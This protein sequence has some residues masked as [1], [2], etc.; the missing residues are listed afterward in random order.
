MN[1]LRL[2]FLPLAALAL[3]SPPLSAQAPRILVGPNVLVSHDEGVAHAELHVAAH[4][5]DAQRLIGMATTVRDAASK[6]TLELY[7][8][9]DGGF[10]WKGS[11]P[12]HLLDKGASDPIVGY[13]LHGTPLGVALGDHGMWVYRSDD[14]GFTWDNGVRAGNGDHERLGID[15]SSGRYAGRLYLAS[16]VIEGRSTSPDTMSRAA[17]V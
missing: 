13:D 15:Y 5:T 6:V 11:V 14:G 1:R 9:D 12:S 3:L 4:P 8:T 17:H 10:T 7:A 16:E 2:G